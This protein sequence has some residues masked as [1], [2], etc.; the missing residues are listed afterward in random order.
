VLIQEAGGMV[1]F[2][3]GAARQWTS[4]ETFVQRALR[5]PFGSD[6]EALRKLFIYMLAGNTQVVQRRAAQ[7]ALRRP[8]RLRRQVRRLWSKL[9]RQKT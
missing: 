4:W 3:N 7:L 5:T 8:L 9:R 2:S 1:L 6:H